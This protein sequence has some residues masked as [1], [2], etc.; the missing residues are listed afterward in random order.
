M[1]DAEHARRHLDKVITV[2]ESWRMCSGADVCYGADSAWWLNRGP[3]PDKFAGERWT[4][5]H[6]WSVPKPPG[7]QTMPS[8][9]GSDIAPPG[10]DFIYTGHNSAFQALGLAVAWGAS[11]VVFL[12]LDLSPAPTGENHWHDDHPEPLVNSVAAYPVFMRAFN[13]AAP[14]LE[15]MGVRV[16]NASRR[17]ALTAFPQMTIEEAC[18]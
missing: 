5:D 10:S 4:Q 13:K 11:C 15:S 1:E 8:K 7:M 9:P 2:N 6:Q 17:T 18:Q 3:T 12:G 16:V 14:T